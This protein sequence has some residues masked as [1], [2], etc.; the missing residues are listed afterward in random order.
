MV[1]KIDHVEIMHR[2]DEACGENRSNIDELRYLQF[3]YNQVDFGVS[4]TIVRKAIN[5]R[6]KKET[7][8]DAPQ[9]YIV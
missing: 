2:L 1:D 5:E 8:K 9:K 6:Y 4:D 3:F 7:G